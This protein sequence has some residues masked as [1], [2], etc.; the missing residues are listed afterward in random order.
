[1][2]A[3]RKIGLGTAVAGIILIATGS[4]AAY[5]S[6]PTTTNTV[7]A[8]LTLAPST[9][10]TANPS[11]E[12]GSVT[13]VSSLREYVKARHEGRAAKVVALD[14]Y[15]ALL[16][17]GPDGLNYR[18]LDVSNWA[19]ANKSAVHMWHYRDGSDGAPVT[20]QRWY[21]ED[22]GSDGSGNPVV[23]MHPGH[24]L[25]KCLDQSQDKP[26]GN[27][28]AV[29]IYS[30]HS[31]ANQQWALVERGDGYLW[32]WNQSGGRRC[33]D[34]ANYAWYDGAGVWVWDCHHGWNQAWA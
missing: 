19:T 2:S 12:D 32:V 28:N 26:D 10:A 25:D 8:A 5:A 31:G 20:N 3:F 34:V 18:V 16:N 22:W 21:L 6:E 27:G 33:L 30:C 1:L 11:P 9:V 29:Y 17:E 4:T 24:A 15:G 13:H 23:R 7:A 14:A